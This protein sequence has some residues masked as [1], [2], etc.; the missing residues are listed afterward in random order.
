VSRTTGVACV[1]F[2][3]LSSLAFAR[4]LA[5]DE[6][7]LGPVYSDGFPDLAVTLEAWPGSDAEGA[8]QPQPDELTLVEDGEAT[9]RARA[10][11]PFGDRGIAVVVAVDVSGTMKGDPLDETRRALA[12]LL[13][14]VG[15]RDRFALLSF[16]DEARVEVGF[17]DPPE[18]AQA[19]IEG[20]SARGELTQLYRALLTALD[21]FD[22]AGDDLPRRRRLIVLSDG[23]NEGAAYSA[24][25]VIA[26]ATRRRVPVDAIGLTRIGES[27]LLN[28]ERLADRTGGHYARAQGADAVEALFARGMARLASTPVATFAAT[29]WSADGRPH[30]LGVLWQRGD[31]VLAGETRVALPAA[32]AETAPDP[33]AEKD[34]AEASEPVAEGWLWLAVALAAVTV[35]ALALFAVAR[36]RRRQPAGDGDEAPFPTTAPAASPPHSAPH[37]PPAQPGRSHVEPALA[38]TIPERESD[39]DAGAPAA[40]AVGEIGPAVATPPPSARKTQFRTVFQPPRPG[41]PSAFLVAE[42]SDGPTVAIERSPLS[43]GAADDAD[44]RV[45]G[46]DYLSSRHAMLRFQDGNLVVD[47]E[48]S[49]NGTFVNEERLTGPRPLAPGDRLRVGRTTF[50]LRPAGSA[51]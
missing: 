6:L 29:T 48:G 33:A 13:A 10:V 46:D 26:E 35:L 18:V 25:D 50:V 21:S 4:P 34:G 39:G 2:A 15:P 1:A 40:P 5:A 41:A 37:S 36:R 17:D 19:A 44:L 43:I 32:A 31:R 47:D 11:E 27:E 30:R 38:E 7:T 28:L 12:T 45:P 8:L 51:G 16:A 14:E 22:A 20:L 42:G 9:R 49:T 3:L 24:D 23:K